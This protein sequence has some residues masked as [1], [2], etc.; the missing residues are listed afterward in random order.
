[1]S[2]CLIRLQQQYHHNERM[3]QIV[4]SFLFHSNINQS[5]K[6]G[7]KIKQH[8]PHQRYALAQKGT[9]RANELLVSKHQRDGK[10]HIHTT[11]TTNT[12]SNWPYGSS[13]VQSPP[14]HPHFV[15]LLCV[16][17]Y[18]RARV[19]WWVWEKKGIV[20]QGV[21]LWQEVKNTV[22]GKRIGVKRCIYANV[23]CLC[24]YADM[25]GAR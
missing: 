12:K 19:W 25:C 18:G 13:S 7:W 24:V 11:T 3:L 6:R 23:V 22:G 10:A 21:K 9:E 16:M 5:N 4:L 20:G 15:C 14:P 17:F 1:M 2:T 8:P